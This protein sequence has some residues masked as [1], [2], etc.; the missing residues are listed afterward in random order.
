M[1]ILPA[2]IAALSVMA[3]ASAQ[4]VA[5]NELGVAMGH[6]HLNVSDVE[7]HRQ[8]WIE[9]FDAV[10]LDRNGLTGVKIPGMLLLFRQQD[11]TGP[12]EGTVVDHFGLKVRSLEEV[13]QRWRAAG[14]EVQREFTGAAGFPNAY[15]L[16]PDGVKIELQQDVGQPEI[17]TAHHLHYFNADY[18]EVRA[19]Y[20]EMFSAILGNRGQV[21]TADLPGINL[22]FGTNRRSSAVPVGTEGRTIDHIGFEVRNLKAFCEQL[23]AKGI[24]FDRPYR[25]NAEIGVSTAFFTDP[26]GAYVELTEGLRQY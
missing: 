14:R 2:V 26:F 11:A 8:L 17:A 18:L 12:S 16:A 25:E 23:E 7:S 20:V 4:L 1:R 24:E 15:I 22:S 3:P 9:H 19:W 5:P 13:L 6:V 10:P 21:D